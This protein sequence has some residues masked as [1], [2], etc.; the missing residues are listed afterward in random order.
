MQENKTE[1]PGENFFGGHQLSN[2]DSLPGKLWW[3][4]SYANY[5]ATVQLIGGLRTHRRFAFTHVVFGLVFLGGGLVGSHA[6]FSTWS[7][8]LEI[9]Y[10]VSVSP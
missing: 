2:S 10:A 5:Q 8:T 3:N 9:C 7:P 4:I 1:T 6:F